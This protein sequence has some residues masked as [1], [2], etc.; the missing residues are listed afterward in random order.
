[1]RGLTSKASAAVGGTLRF[2]GNG[3][4]GVVVG[5]MQGIEEMIESKDTCRV[6]GVFLCRRDGDIIAR[7]DVPNFYE[8]EA[9]VYIHPCAPWLKV[10]ARR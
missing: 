4:D 9:S 6:G 3:R 2:S 5:W 10:V 1:M 7:G 8:L